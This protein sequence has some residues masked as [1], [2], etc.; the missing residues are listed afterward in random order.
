MA[1]YLSGQCDVLAQRCWVADWYANGPQDSGGGPSAAQY[2]RIAGDFVDAAA[3]EELNNE[4]VW[5]RRSFG[6]GT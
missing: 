4:L 1:A 2:A 5:Y 6:P 3:A